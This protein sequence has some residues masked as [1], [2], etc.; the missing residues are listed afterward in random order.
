MRINGLIG[1]GVAVAIGTSAWAQTP[2]APAAGSGGGGAV[3]PSVTAPTRPTGQ[4]PPGTPT[5]NTTAGSMTRD[6]AGEKVIGHTV[7]PPSAVPGNTGAQG[8][9]T[10]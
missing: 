4:T 2:A 3:G 7:N 9:G 5:G 6:A 8:T 1:F 10:K